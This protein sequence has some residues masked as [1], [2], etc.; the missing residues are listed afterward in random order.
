MNKLLSKSKVFIKKNASIILTTVGGAGVVITSVMAVKATPKALK[1][2]EQATDEKGDDLTKTEAIIVAG[3]AYIPAIVTGVSTIACI[4]GANALNKR[5][6]ASLMSAYALVNNSYKEY[7]GKVQELYGEDANDNVQ[8]EIAKDKY[9]KSEVTNTDGEELFYDEFSGRYFTSTL[10]KLQHAEYQLNR[11][12][13]MM[14]CVDLNSYYHYLGLPTIDGGDELGWSTGM[15]F[16]YYWQPWI[17]FSHSR[18]ELED[19]TE[20]I[21][22]WMIHEPNVGYAEY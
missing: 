18:F 14:D 6:Q 17:D 20:C 9:D 8:T 19:G 21:K 13:V 1:A 7:R 5:Q 16:D 2:L 15:N 10:Y 4:F 11:D 3:P 22:I 12:L